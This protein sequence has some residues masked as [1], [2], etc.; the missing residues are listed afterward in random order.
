MTCDCHVTFSPLLQVLDLQMGDFEV[1]EQSDTGVLFEEKKMVVAVGTTDDL[2]KTVSKKETK[3]PEI[4]EMH[5]CM[6]VHTFVCNTYVRTSVSN[7]HC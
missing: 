6:Y 4:V 1:P 5:T 2:E 7:Q 3:L